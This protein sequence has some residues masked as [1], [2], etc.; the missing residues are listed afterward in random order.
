ME[1]KGKVSISAQIRQQCKKVLV[2]EIHLEGQRKKGISYQV[3]GYAEPWK[4]ERTFCYQEEFVVL[5]DKCT[6]RI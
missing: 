2:K 4:Y 3:L 5:N 6:P 1:T